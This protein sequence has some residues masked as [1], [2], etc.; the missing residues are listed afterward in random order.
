LADEFTRLALLICNTLNSPSADQHERVCRLNLKLQEIVPN[1]RNLPGFSHFLL[2]SLFP[3][4]QHAASRG[5]VIIANASQYSCDA[6]I[7]FLD[8]DP[9][10]IPLQVTQE[11]VRDLSAELHT[12]T[13]RARR[14]DM[15]KEL[16]FFLRK[17]WDQIVSPIVDCLKATRPFQSRIWWCPTAEF[18]V[19]PLHVAGPYRKGQQNLPHLYISSYTPTLTA[20]IR[21]RRHDPSTSATE[22]K[23][24]IAIGQAKAAGESELV[25]V[26]A[27]LNNIG[28]RVD[29]L[30]TFTCI[31]GEESCTSRVVEELGKNE[32]VHLACHGLPN[33][34]EPFE[35]A[36]ALHDGHFTIQ[37]II[38]C[39]FKNP[40]FAY[41]SACHTTVGDEK[42]PDEVIHLASAMQFVG[43]RSVIGT[44]WAVDDGETNKI[45]STFY[46]HMVDE[47]GRLDHTR[48]AFALNKT[49][50]SVN[51]PF[52]Q[53]I[54]Y[55]HLGA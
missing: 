20:L 7:V 10:H 55:I 3:D 46:M 33:R 2:P 49:M 15:T 41:L 22:P 48:A 27:E 1:I 17:L 39:D 16:A 35:S 50:K 52:D 11:D 37:R 45:T 30:A 13:V 42:S 36:F 9:V 51:I 18:S 24:F 54:L 19:L 43:F 29:G 14:A 25:S 44:M 23:R 34:K 4:L 6:L 8:R 32:W 38:G 21:A 31:D 47:S 5:P 28:Q 40:E 26:G 12:L 53:R